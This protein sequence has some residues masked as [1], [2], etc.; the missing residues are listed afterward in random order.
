M[1][2]ITPALVLCQ[3]IIY[4]DLMMLLL[5]YDPLRLHGNSRRPICCEIYHKE[6]KTIRGHVFC[7]FLALTLKKS[8]RT[9]VSPKGWCMGGPNQAGPDTIQEG[10][11]E[12]QGRK[13][14]VRRECVGICDTVFKAVGVA[15]PPTIR[16]AGKKPK[17][18]A[19]SL[20]AVQKN[21]LY[22]LQPADLQE[23]FEIR[24]RRSHQDVKR[25]STTALSG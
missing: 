13:V 8:R 3:T 4:C 14:A 15:V 17:R 6:N 1:K 24:C 12:E 10:F 19:K 25:A 22:V 2:V 20:N 21:Q 5:D 11:R 9:G 23:H 16:I 7:R 18:W